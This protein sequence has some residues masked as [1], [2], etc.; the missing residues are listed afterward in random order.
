MRQNLYISWK[1]GETESR[2]IEDVNYFL[3]WTDRGLNLPT[4]ERVEETRFKSWCLVATI[5]LVKCQ[6]R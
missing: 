6:G 5:V 4:G 3:E 1:K 2:D